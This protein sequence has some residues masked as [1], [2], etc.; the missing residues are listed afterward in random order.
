[1]LPVFCPYHPPMGPWAHGQAGPPSRAQVTRKPARRTRKTARPRASAGPGYPK[2]GPGHAAQRPEPL[3]RRPLQRLQKPPPPQREAATPPFGRFWAGLPGNRPRAPAGRPSYRPWG[4]AWVPDPA[5]RVLA[6]A[7]DS[8]Q[9]GL[10]G[11][12]EETSSRPRR[13]A[14]G[15]ARGTQR[16]PPAPQARGGPATTTAAPVAP[17]ARELRPGRRAGLPG[18]ARPSLGGLTRRRSRP[19]VGR[20]ARQR[21]TPK[22]GRGYPEAR[23]RKPGREAA[24]GAG[25]PT[26]P[27]LGGV[28]RKPPGPRRTTNQIPP[29]LLLATRGRR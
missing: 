10:Y 11:R 26:R 1:M 13:P 8:R 7:S 29:F 24:L 2:A 28:T 9:K 3:P 17:A 5:G 14:Q 16:T 21:P 27:S 20:V 18:S 4:P 6:Y 19:R 12:V 23:R 15:A 22:S 25:A